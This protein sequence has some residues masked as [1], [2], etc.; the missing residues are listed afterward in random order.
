M[1]TLV[2]DI[3]PNY[4]IRLRLRALT[5]NNAL[6]RQAT[7]S[8]TLNCSPARHVAILLRYFRAAESGYFVNHVSPVMLWI[9]AGGARVYPLAITRMKVCLRDLDTRVRVEGVKG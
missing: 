3:P 4:P 7:H 5:F 2:R 8:C 6:L 1:A 9:R